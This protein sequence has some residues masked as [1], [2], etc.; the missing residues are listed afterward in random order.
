MSSS[1]SV[2]VNSIRTYILIAWIV[3]IAILA[4]WAILFVYYFV[5]IFIVGMASSMGN[6]YAPYYLSGYYIGVGLASGIV[7]LIL[8][9]PS[10]LV[11]RRV[12]KMKAAIDQEDLDTV[13]KLNTTG[14]AI[15]ALIFA[16]VIP[17]IMLFL[18]NSQM[19]GTRASSKKG[20][21]SDS[22]DKMVKLKSLLDSGVITK[23]EF[24]AQKSALLN[25]QAK[26]A[27][28]LEDKLTKLKALYDSGTLTESEYNEQK[29]KLLS[30]L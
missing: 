22:L 10:F 8:I 9:I 20:V 4:I 12:R 21:S 16:G 28:G 3:T 13:K 30:D 26:Q 7:F 6:P 29:K 5:W 1:D 11:F 19:T 27:S 23:E 2:D 14:W 17:G 18:T 24:E 15:I 25:P